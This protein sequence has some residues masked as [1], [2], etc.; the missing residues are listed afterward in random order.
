MPPRPARPL[1]HSSPRFH[2]RPARAFRTGLFNAQRW[3]VFG[4]HACT[5]NDARARTS[6]FFLQVPYW[7]I[8]PPSSR[9]ERGCSDQCIALRARAYVPPAD[10][11]NQLLFE[12]LDWTARCTQATVTLSSGCRSGVDTW[13]SLLPSLPRSC[14]LPKWSRV[15]YRCG[16][17][18]HVAHGGDGSDIA[19]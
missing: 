11:K 1:D 6:R 5:W 15:S 9:L 14:A 18:A 16:F 3:D 12:A 17:L 8:P 13:G 19:N 2:F 7:R 10:G 4:N